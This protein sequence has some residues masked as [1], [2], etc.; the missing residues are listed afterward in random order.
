M[1]KHR[2]AVTTMMVILFF[3]AFS[4]SGCSSVRDTRVSQPPVSQ[5]ETF[6]RAVDERTLTEEER[7]RLRSEELVD[8]V[9]TKE[10][11]QARLIAE[12][13]AFQASPIHFD[14]NR[15]DLRP[16][17]RDVLD[18]LGEWLL[19]NRNFNV[20]IEGHCDER[21]TAE[22]NLALGERRAQA[23][24]SYLLDLGVENR[25]I[26]T[27]SYGEERPLDPGSNEEAWAANRRAQFNILPAR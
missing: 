6:D 19:K 10:Q 1:N 4:M 23:A 16:E 26:N 7:A 5:A 13:Q 25:R 9:L 15:Y 14:L 22:Y 17:A 21:G 8:E 18:L 12:A 20:T 27:V 2:R 24:R 3:L 11:K